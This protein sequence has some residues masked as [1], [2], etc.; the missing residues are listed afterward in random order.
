MQYDDLVN[1]PSFAFDDEADYQRLAEAA[2]VDGCE[3]DVVRR[4]SYGY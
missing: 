4:V 1:V 3:N 2:I